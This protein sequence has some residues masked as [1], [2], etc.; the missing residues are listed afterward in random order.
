V[1]SRAQKETEVAELRDR[2]RR[3]TSVIVA[4]YRGVDVQGVSRL[5]RRLRSEGEAYEY[6][7]AKNTLLRR[8]VADLGAEALRA[9][10]VGPTAVAF[11]FADPVAL[12]R[13]LVDYARENEAFRLKAGWLEG[14]AIDARAIATLATLPPLEHLRARLLGLLQAPAAQLARVV[15]APAAQLARLVEARRARLAEPGS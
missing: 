14:R 7:V 3:A 10:F 2:F 9:H 5:R 12:A 4:D 6:R 13:V 8:A 15:Q 1:L 11:S